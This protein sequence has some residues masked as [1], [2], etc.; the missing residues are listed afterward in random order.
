MRGPLRLKKS[1]FVASTAIAITLGFGVFASPMSP[2]VSSA[3]AV[4]CEH[5]LSAGRYS[6]TQ[7]WGETSIVDCTPGWVGSV[8]LDLYAE[9]CTSDFLG[10]CLNWQREGPIMGYLTGYGNHFYYLPATG[11]IVQGGHL[12]DN[13]YHIVTLAEITLSSG[14]YSDTITT[15]QFRL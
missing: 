1:R 7:V 4:V 3:K 6:D 11:Y 9:R 10:A 8:Y 14:V 12:N 5:T 2:F 13:L 15:Q